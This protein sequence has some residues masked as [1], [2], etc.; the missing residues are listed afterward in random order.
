MPR[1]ET[2]ADMNLNKYTEKAQEAVLGA[3]QMA[4]RAGHPE[5]LPEHLALTLV[6]QPDGIVPAVL[7]KMQ[8][9]A[10]ALAQ[11]LQGLV[12]K[13]PRVQGG[14]VGLGRR[15]QQLSQAAEDEAQRL[16]DEFT[17]TE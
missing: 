10:S 11:E 9:D 2:V 16:K 6:T 5:L 17:S 8:V 15:S 4:E 12:D 13:L 7:A 1:V 14:Q 3:Q